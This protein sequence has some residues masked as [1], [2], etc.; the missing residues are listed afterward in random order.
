MYFAHPYCSGE[1]GTNEN[2]NGLLRQ[3][4]PK[5]TNLLKVTQDQVNDSVYCL[6][7]QPRKRLGYRTPH[8]V[9]YGLEMRP[10]KLTTYALCS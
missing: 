7:H 1:G 6:N 2:H 5:K 8:E 9:L 3:L 10:L 4:F